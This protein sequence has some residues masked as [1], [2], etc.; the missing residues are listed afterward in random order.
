MNIMKSRIK[1]GGAIKVIALAASFIF[2]IGAPSAAASEDEIEIGKEVY[3]QACSM[4]HNSGMVGSPRLDRP[5][6]WDERITKSID[7]LVENT[8]NGLGNMPPQ[9]RFDEQKIRATIKYI[10]KVVEKG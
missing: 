4:C 9:E 1:K 8:R 10:L 3:Q 5:S 7:E 6:E 2:Y